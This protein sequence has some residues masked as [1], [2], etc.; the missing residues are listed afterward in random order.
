MAVVEVRVLGDVEA[1]SE[2]RRIEIGHARQQCVLAVL[3]VEVNRTVTADQLLERAWS[4]HPPRRGRQVLRT[5]LSRLRTSLAPAGLVIERRPTGYVLP[6]DQ[7]VVDVH[8]FRRLIAHARTA[9]DEQAIGLFD[10]A[11]ALWRGEPFAGLDTPWLAAVRTGLER[12]RTAARLDRVDVALRCGRHAEVLPELFTLTDLDALDERVA[13]QLMLALHRAGR[14]ADALAHYRQLRAQLVEQ[15]GTEAGIALRE[16]H[17][18]ILDTDPALTP[19][20]AG[21]T[22]GAASRAEQPV[23]RQLPAPPRWFT[24]RSTELA[25]L[26]QALTAEPEQDPPRSG[27]GSATPVAATVVISA[28]GGAG[29]I[30][31]TW[32]VLAWAHQHAEQFPDGQ[33]FVDLRGYSPAQEPMPPEAAVHRFLDALGVDPGRIPTD[34]DAQ[35]ALYRSLVANRR[36]LIVLDNAATA[37]QVVPLLPGSPTCTVLVTGRTRPASLVDRHG[38]RYLPLDV[39]ARDEARALLAA[40]LGADRVAA[41]L[42]AVDELVELCGGYPL[43][44]SIAARHATCPGISLAEVVAELRELGLEMLDHDTD[45]SASLPTV[46]SW[47]LHR[48]TDEHRTV[49]G[50]LGIAPGPDIGAP[51]VAALTGLSA[52]RAR[53]ALSALEEASLV[54]RRAHGRYSMHDLIRRYATNTAHQLVADLRVAALRRVIDFYLHTAHAADRALDP[55]TPSIRLDSPTPGAHPLQ[56]SDASAALAWL[57]IEH[58]HL[59]AAQR[60]AVTHHWH[61]TAWQLACVLDTFHQRRGHTREALAVWQVAVDAADH[62]TD[63]TTRVHAARR[64]GGAYVQL[65]RYEQAVGHLRQ[66]LALAEHQPELAQLAHTHYALALAWGWWKD[67]RQPLE[68]AR[69]ALDLFRALDNPVW[70]GDALNLMGWLA[71]RL[72]EYDTARAHCQEALV[73]CRD[74]DYPVGEAATLDS[75]GLIDHHTGQHQQAIHHYRQALALFRELDTTAEVADTLDKLGHPHAALG[76][77]DQAREAWQEALELYREQGRDDDAARMQRQLDDLAPATGA[78]RLPGAGDNNAQNA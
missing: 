41:E 16:L 28:I 42:G 7:D 3:V 17:Q 6:A 77:H 20:S 54:E 61:E 73:L 1:W 62:L 74:H 66:A 14:T 5:Y 4:G 26:D 29:G 38:A 52:A 21:I 72:G 2:D 36:M 78:N 76:Q 12:E 57:K 44:L 9:D 24:G 23:P 10:E 51:A 22:G 68:H 47:S 58:P 35:A 31:K 27:T 48:L 60:T 30:G 53:R 59:L 34:L 65:G 55:H 32:L 71:F 64:L 33:L 43:A 11:L 63:P 37:D 15:L 46:L 69:C 8:R 70:E 67:D 75:L 18:R 49:F 50:L 45:P 39:L 40:R 13:A 19:P 25:R 56:L